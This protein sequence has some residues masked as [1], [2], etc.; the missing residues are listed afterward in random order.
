M[1]SR[2]WSR[3]QV[4]ARMTM[5]ALS[6]ASAAL[7]GDVAAQPS[8]GLALYSG[9]ELY[10]ECKR[11]TGADSLC[12]GF[13]AGAVDTLAATDA[14]LLEKKVLARRTFC[15]PAGTT[16]SG[17]QAVVVRYLEENRREHH[18]L[19]ASLVTAAVQSAFPCKA[20]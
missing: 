15:P 6:L 10:I 5:A 19:A 18:Y 12:A 9:A 4:P 3:L 17:F 7:A 1:P 13:V 8:G 2:N 11:P 14:L 20:K 16:L